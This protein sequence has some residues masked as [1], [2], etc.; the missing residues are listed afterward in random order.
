M[1]ISVLGPLYPRQF[2]PSSRRLRS[3]YL[4]VFLFIVFPRAFF[5]RPLPLHQRP[6][7][8]DRVDTKAQ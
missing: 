7:Q 6:D 4:Y 1:V 8:S 2:P 3:T 5:Y